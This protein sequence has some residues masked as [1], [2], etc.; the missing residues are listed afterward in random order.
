[1]SEQQET[2]QKNSQKKFI[3]IENKEKIKLTDSEQYISPYITFDI[4]P[5]AKPRMTQRDKWKKRDIVVKYWKYKDNLKWL[6]LLNKWIPQDEL[7]VEFILPMPKY[8]S[9]TKK[10][11]MNGQ[12]HKQ[13]PDL[14]NL[15]KGFQDALLKEDS[16]IHTYLK[17]KKEWGRLGQIKVKR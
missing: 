10:I 9:E 13:R 5:I 6:C 15:V 1:M 2:K 14:D 4:T 12:P 8:W 16:H 3:N 17:T 7:D 11:S